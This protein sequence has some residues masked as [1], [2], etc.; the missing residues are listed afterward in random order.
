MY[1]ASSSPYQPMQF[2]GPGGSGSSGQTPSSAVNGGGYAMEYRHQQ[3]VQQQN[4]SVQSVHQ[5][6]PPHH[7]HSQQNGGMRQPNGPTPTASQLS[8][9]ASA[10]P[11]LPTKSPMVTHKPLLPPPG[12]SPSSSSNQSVPSVG[13]GSSNLKSNL[14]GGVSGNSGGGGGGD[15]SSVGLDKAKDSTKMFPTKTYNHIKDMISSR[16]GNNNS[17][18]SAS[19]GGM[20]PKGLNN[21]AANTNSSNSN[22]ANTTNGNFNMNGQN[23][24][25]SYMD[26]SPASSMG[27]PSL[28]SYGHSHGHMHGHM[29]DSYG[30]APTYYASP[31]AM[32][33]PGNNNGANNSGNNQQSMMNGANSYRSPPMN[34]R[35]MTHQ[36][37]ISRMVQQFSGGNNNEENR[38]MYPNGYNGAQDKG[39]IGA[40]SSSSGASQLTTGGEL[41]AIPRNRFSVTP[42]PSSS[43]SNS[44]GGMG[45]GSAATAHNTGGMSVESSLSSPSSSS[46]TH[47]SKHHAPTT[48]LPN[49]NNTGSS[50]NNNNNKS[51]GSNNNDQPPPLP[52]SQ[53]PEVS[54]ASGHSSSG[55]SHHHL[56]H[57]HNHNTL[58]LPP[59]LPSV[60]VG[61]KRE[62]GDGS[63]GTMETP[64]S[65]TIHLESAQGATG[66]AA[67]GNA[68]SALALNKSKSEQL[69]KITS[70][71]HNLAISVAAEQHFHNH[72]LQF[73]SGSGSNNNQ[74]SSSECENK[75]SQRIGSGQSHTTSDSG[76]GT[77]M[78]TKSPLNSISDQENKI[79]ED[80]LGGENPKFGD[81]VMDSV[82]SGNDS[83]WVDIVEPEIRQI[84]ELEK[85]AKPG[86][87]LRPGEKMTGV[88]LVT[89]TPAHITQGHHGKVNPMANGNPSSS[90]TKNGEQP[91]L[92]G[93][94]TASPIPHHRL[95]SGSPSQSPKIP[96]KFD[97]NSYNKKA[98]QNRSQELLA[99]PSG[100]S[101]AQNGGGPSN[102]KVKSPRST[103]KVNR[104]NSGAGQ[105]R[106][107]GRSSRGDKG[108]KNANAAAHRL[109][110]DLGLKG[111]KLSRHAASQI[112]YPH[113]DN[114][115]MTSTT[116]GLDL[117]SMLDGQTEQTSD[118]DDDM[119]TTIDT[120]DAHAIRRQLESLESMYTEVLKVL[121]AKRFSGNR[122]P[123]N[124]LRNAKR[125]PYGSM[126]SLPSSVSSRPFRERKLK[127]DDK[128]K[129]KDIKS[130]NKRFQRLESHVVTLARSVAHLSSEMRTQHMM[131]QEIESIRNEMQ[132]LRNQVVKS[133]MQNQSAAAAAAQNF[134]RVASGRN[135]AGVNLVSTTDWTSFRNALPSLTNPCRVRKLTKFF[136]DEPPLVRIFL[137]KLG[138]EKYASAFEQER[139][140]IMELPYLTEE[141]LNKMGIPMG[142]RLR[143]LQEAQLCLKPGYHQTHESHHTH[144]QSNNHGPGNLSFWDWQNW[145][146]MT[147]GVLKNLIQA[148]D[149]KKSAKNTKFFDDFVEGI[150][151]FYNV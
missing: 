118:D 30:S 13:S 52:T 99:G 33:P 6:Q 36:N 66:A 93:D 89:S 77:V 48:S 88:P 32:S 51:G 26:S 7:H 10:S 132:Q 80:L 41:G 78:L 115:D 27:I 103:A 15:T 123:T 40:T 65:G 87:S 24:M 19:S 94:I 150:S 141:R 4:L 18:A 39:K 140:G 84:L 102:S 73:A 113:D 82:S 70:D 105:Q 146:G 47:S 50:S 130:I 74:S 58:G 42:G 75:G 106:W 59:V 8:Y 129:V 17:A 35:P 45:A 34:D 133:S 92:M 53:K 23:G 139:I 63:S 149:S 71:L 138:Y 22:G 126:S 14:N 1:L 83:E 124:D 143:I 5:S 104:S 69:K 62:N 37:G 28:P 38:A 101:G 9:N 16:F 127:L 114:G 3:Q 2:N 49:G 90:H 111:I 97:L 136:G 12:P 54:G 109:I 72:H 76:V 91:D 61:E 98:S 25:N 95:M 134:A 44:S 110:K 112:L 85:K 128:K 135:G 120:T 148:I 121:G 119:S 142:P 60:L 56:H 137:K 125:R 144:H 46:Y 117:E 68:S 100:S 116:T 108:G 86:K 57:L 64:S 31:P 151:E 122:Y 96:K 81:N 145:N 11:M 131:V 20:P 29:H 55:L 43:T 21:S 67:S 107:N 79:G 147:Q